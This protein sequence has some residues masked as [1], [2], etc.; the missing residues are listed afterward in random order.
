MTEQE[1][2][3]ESER[4]PEEYI[5]WTGGYTDWFLE[6]DQAIYY[7]GRYLGTGFDAY[8]H[9]SSSGCV[10]HQGRK[11]FEE[12]DRLRAARH[13]GHQPTVG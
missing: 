7:L 5:V 3:Q 13:P 8:G 12:M 6:R 9:P 2:L 4:E 1:V 11:V 10:Y